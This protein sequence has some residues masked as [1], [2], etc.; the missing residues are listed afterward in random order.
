[1]MAKTN[2]PETGLNDRPMTWTKIEARD[3]WGTTYF[4]PVGR[5]QDRNGLND[6]RLG[7]KLNAGDVLPVRFPDGTVSEVTLTMTTK[8]GTIEDH[9]ND[10]RYSDEIPGFEVPLA[11]GLGKAW[12]RIDTVELWLEQPVGV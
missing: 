4:A 11:L 3:D 9:G 5:S 8:H 10:H 7:L 2:L 6:H 12:L 1:M